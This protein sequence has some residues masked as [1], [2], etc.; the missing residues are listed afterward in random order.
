MVPVQ[1]APALEDP[2]R[3]R[4]VSLLRLGRP[5]E[6]LL[7]LRRYVLAAPGD[8]EGYRLLGLALEAHGDTD[9]AGSQRRL[10][11]LVGDPF[12]AGTQR[13]VCE[14]ARTGSRSF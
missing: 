2:R 5:L 6:A 12:F 13:A 9:A 10:A 4:A 8:P 7:P 3:E 14:I 11:T 1:G